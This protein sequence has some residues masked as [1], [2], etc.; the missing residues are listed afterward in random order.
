MIRQ[1]NPQDAPSCYNLIHNCISEDSSLS[2]AVRRKLLESETP[3]SMEERARFFYVAVHESESRITGLAG[4]DLN[5][6]RLMYVSPEHRRSGIGRALLGH[7]AAMAPK[8]FF[9]DL[10]VYSSIAAVDFY[11]SQ[12]F[13]AKGSVSFDIGG[14]IMRTMFM[15]CASNSF[16]L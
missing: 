2:A 7:I 1:F 6:I 16:P 9:K 8:A 14:E 13:V 11:R 10:F 12:G 3:Q 5:E 4:L 15:A